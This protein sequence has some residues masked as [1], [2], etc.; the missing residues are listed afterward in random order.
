[1]SMTEAELKQHTQEV[2][3]QLKEDNQKAIAQ[4]S[5]LIELLGREFVQNYV[6]KT[7]EIEAKGGLK[8]DDGSRRRTTGGVFF[9]LIKVAVPD[10]VRDKIFPRFGMRRTGN[11]IKWEER[12]KYV[13]EM[14]AEETAE[15]GE[16]HS[17]EIR[18][19]GR[20]GKILVEDNS[21]VTTLTHTHS[22]VPF[23]YGVPQPPTDVS[24]VYVVYM[25]IRKWRDVEEFIK[26]AP[27]DVLIVDGTLIWDAESSTLA[28][29][30]RNV[31]TRRRERDIRRGIHSP[32]PSEDGDYDDDEAEETPKKAKAKAQP[33]PE[34]EPA[35]EI[36][37]GMSA[38]DYAQFKKLQTAAD[39]Y[40]ERIKEMEA[41][42]NR[43]VKMTKTLLAN[44]ENQIRKLE[45]K[46]DL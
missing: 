44:T 38:G 10:E 3:E 36:P 23:A 32:V 46:Y 18:V 21:V 11:V 24:T 41:S 39:K 22:S 35:E 17:V 6:E 45:Q 1:M 12:M 43:G 16:M 13:A 20:P 28:V 4:I 19:K 15:H 40:R 42:G 26:R 7:K 30:A 29:F 33:E 31:T 9:Y 2:A 8:T 37:N 5:K 14:V 27:S 34:P 25:P